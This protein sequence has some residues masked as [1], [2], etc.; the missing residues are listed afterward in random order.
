MIF[1][2]NKKQVSYF[3][4]IYFLSISESRGTA[5]HFSIFLQLNWGKTGKWVYICSI[6]LGALIYVNIVKP[7]ESC[8]LTYPLPH[9]AIL[10]IFAVR[11]LKP[12]SLSK[13]QE[14]N[15]I[16]SSF[17]FFCEECFVKSVFLL[18]V[19]NFMFYWNCFS[20]WL[21]CPSIF[22]PCYLSRFKI[23]HRETIVDDNKIL[24]TI[25]TAGRTNIY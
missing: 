4:L 11:T 23:Y 3:W 6:Q 1:I 16:L 13:L 12:S 21:T 20:S 8:G 14:C 18:F 25:L 19:K 9:T 24:M 7:S 22:L 5:F 2:S 10:Y 15:K 17:L